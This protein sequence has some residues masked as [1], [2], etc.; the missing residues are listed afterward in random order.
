MESKMWN[1]ERVL[2]TGGTGMVAKYIR[3][4]L[5]RKYSAIVESPSRETLNLECKEDVAAFFKFFK[6][7]YVFHMA[8]RV[9]GLG[10]N[11]LYPIETLSANIII[12]DSV[13]SAC[14]IDSVKKIFFAG[15]V[16]SYQYPYSRLPLSEDDIFEG[17]PHVGE[18]GYAMAKR[19]AFSYLKL[20][21]EKYGKEFVYGAYTNL[22]GP[23]DRFN[24]VSGHVIPSL[25][26][27][28][29][30]SMSEGRKL[31][32]WGRP[33]TT[34]DFLYV[35]DAAAAAIHLM[36]HHSGVINIA[37]GAESTMSEL[38]EALVEVS[39]FEGEVNWETSKPVGIARRYSDVS[40]LN[41]SGFNAQFSL[42]SGLKATW[43]WY[44]NAVKNNETIRG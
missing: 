24:V 30:A 41:A 10:G 34:R 23:H 42:L 15:T 39:G 4:A 33:D 43:D 27:K 18:Y 26:M 5:E 7:K 40:R 22:Y 11:L 2:I 28:L 17:D 3:D 1:K 32:V 31:D 44:C 21:N 8:G 9:H 38:I 14:N 12:N 6:P 36:E 13:L 20:L 25:I 19:L 37:S 29:G 35:E 16:A